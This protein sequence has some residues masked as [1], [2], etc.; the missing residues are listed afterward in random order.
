MK[1]GKSFAPAEELCKKA[2]ELEQIIET[3]WEAHTS[4][5]VLTNDSGLQ[6]MYQSLA[7]VKALK[8]NGHL[9]EGLFLNMKRFYKVH[10]YKLL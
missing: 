10:V 9:L 3:K 5:V 1:V 6:S 2:Q 7:K 4:Q 8:E